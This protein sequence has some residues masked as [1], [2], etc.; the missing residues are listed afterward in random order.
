MTMLTRRALLTGGACA[1]T[2]VSAPPGFLARA[3]G[4]AEARGKVL[5]A[6]FQRGAVDGLSMVPPHGDSAYQ[7]ARASIAIGRPR[8]GDTAA[9]HDLD[10]FFAL[11]PALAPLVPLWTAAT[12]APPAD[13]A[14]AGRRP[15]LR[16]AG[17]DALAL[18]RPGL[19]GDRH[20]RREEHARRLAL[21]RR[22]GAA[23]RAP[24][25]V[26]LGGAGHQA[27]PRSARRR[28]RT[29]AALAGALRGAVDGR[30]RD[31]A[32]SEERRVGNEPRH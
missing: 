20:A 23:A 16:L 31:R 24:D 32:R 21:P 17:A 12:P 11:H 26:P 2:A 8:V 29:G 18:R 13:R 22:G 19:H 5:V 27:A 15:R 9:A 30:A 28:L 10:G 7:A 1:L 25:A 3:A 14:D 6:V 4:A